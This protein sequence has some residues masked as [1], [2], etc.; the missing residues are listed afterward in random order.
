MKISFKLLLLFM[1]TK[2]LD[3]KCIRIYDTSEEIS[4]INVFKEIK[5]CKKAIEQEEVP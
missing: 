4:D 3:L 2:T 1:M 5:R